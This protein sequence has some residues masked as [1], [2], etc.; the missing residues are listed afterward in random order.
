MGEPHH[1][2][3]HAHAQGALRRWEEPPTFVC[4]PKRVHMRM[5]LYRALSAAG[6]AGG[7]YTDP[8]FPDKASVVPAWY[9]RPGYLSAMAKNIFSQGTVAASSSTVSPRLRRSVRPG[10]GQ[11]TR[12]AKGSE[13]AS[14]PGHPSACRRFAHRAR[15]YLSM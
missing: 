15:Q 6:D 14:S 12:E 8:D 1:V 2:R 3:V 5:H 9:N 11:Q 7:L 10:R 4:M 13:T